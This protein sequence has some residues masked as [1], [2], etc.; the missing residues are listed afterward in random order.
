MSELGSIKSIKSLV[1]DTRIEGDKLHVIFEATPME[2][3]IEAV[4]PARISDAQREDEPFFFN[5]IRAANDLIRDLAG[6]T[7]SVSAA[8]VAVDSAIDRAEG[9]DKP[10]PSAP[11]S[12]EELDDA[13]YRAFSRVMHLFAWDPKAQEWVIIHEAQGLSAEL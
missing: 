11:L 10:E 9:D 3:E 1:K 12:A 8:A 13:I 7:A 4:V 6:Y 5:A 2:G